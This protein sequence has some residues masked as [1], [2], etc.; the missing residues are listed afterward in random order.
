MR[1]LVLAASALAIAFSSVPYVAAQNSATGVVAY[2]Q[3]TM[4][5][6][7]A[8]LNSVKV[9]LQE[10]PELIDQASIHATAIEDLAVV[11]PTMFPEGSADPESDALPAIWE[12]LSGFEA[13][14]MKL[15]ETSA[16][17]AEAATGGDVQAVAQAFAAVGKDG[18]GGCHNEYRA[19]N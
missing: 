16:A 3:A 18:C 5:A 13:S 9:L 6:I 19:K 1:K 14:A 7:G 12:D 15:Q 8:H 4:K 17:L 10:Q 11:I 2:R